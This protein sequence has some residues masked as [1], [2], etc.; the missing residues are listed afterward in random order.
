LVVSI[1]AV[2]QEH[3][4]A[5]KEIRRHK[6]PLVA[7]RERL[8]DQELVAIALRPCG[9]EE[10]A[11]AAV[12]HLPVVVLADVRKEVQNEAADVNGRWR[13]RRGG[14]RDE[15]GRLVF[16]V[17]DVVVVVTDAYRV[18]VGAAYAGMEAG[19]GDHE[20]PSP[21]GGRGADEARGRA[22]A[23]QDVLEE[24]IWEVQN[25][26]CRLGISPV[27]SPATPL[28][29]RRHQRWISLSHGFVLRRFGR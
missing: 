13:S 3:A 28:R 19:I 4:Q 11:S 21:T 10:E 14:D 24:V 2:D 18:W 20:A 1:V 6:D 9:E 23:E 15:D 16:I 17:E 26:R 22:E 5:E 27:L 8:A 12:G 25:G 7:P 29:R